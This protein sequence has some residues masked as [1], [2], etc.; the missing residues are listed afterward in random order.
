VVRA[1]AEDKPT[2]VVRNDH[3]STR[4][5]AE[6]GG[7][8]Q[9]LLKDWEADPWKVLENAF[10]GSLGR[11]FPGWYLRGGNYR[12]PRNSSRV[13]GNHQARLGSRGGSPGLEM[14]HTLEGLFNGIVGG[15]CL[16]VAQLVLR[17]FGNHEFTFKLPNTY[18]H[19]VGD[20]D[21]DDK[22]KRVLWVWSYLVRQVPQSKVDMAMKVLLQN[23]EGDTRQEFED[24]E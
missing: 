5:L 10:A 23:W 17:V 1:Y 12:L 18:C 22:S 14:V 3:G 9:V 19:R 2:S 16:R 13:E 21:S 6:N 20:V 4:R 7:L 8:S 11:S 24:M 15:Q